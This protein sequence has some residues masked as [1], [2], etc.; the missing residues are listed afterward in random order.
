LFDCCVVSGM[1]LWPV[2]ARCRSQ[3]A[4]AMSSEQ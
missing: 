1:F 4:A 3:P 2:V